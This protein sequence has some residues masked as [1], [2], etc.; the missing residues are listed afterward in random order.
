MLIWTFIQRKVLLNIIVERNCRFVV[1]LQIILLCSL[2]FAHQAQRGLPKPQIPDTDSEG[3][4]NTNPDL[5]SNPG[6]IDSHDSAELHPL[7]ALPAD[8]DDDSDYSLGEPSHLYNNPAHL[9]NGTMYQPQPGIE[10]AQIYHSRL[11]GEQGHLQTAPMPRSQRS[12][13]ETTVNRLAKSEGYELEADE[14]IGSQS[15][16]SSPVTAQPERPPQEHSP[17]VGHEARQGD[18]SSRGGE[19]HHEAEEVFG[20]AVFCL[21]FG[22]E[23]C[24]LRGTLKL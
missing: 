23:I 1:Q 21:K 11:P 12:P 6:S 16:H 17:G 15:F 9:R 7:S 24:T 13:R 10:P 18:T 3:G 22:V 2:L 19:A 14:G 20:T 4:C 8:D 5:Y